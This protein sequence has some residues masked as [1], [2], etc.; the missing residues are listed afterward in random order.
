VISAVDGR[1]A[2]TK[3]SQG[4]EI[5]L[6]FSDVVMPGGISGWDLAEIAREKWPD[7]RILLS[8]GYSLET[9][10]SRRSGSAN[11]RVLDKPYRK[12][13][14]ARSVSEIFAAETS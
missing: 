1:D 7:L 4:I 9:L 11:L 13:D 8:S 6:L 2:I 5:D 14:L 12:A 10:V 3:L